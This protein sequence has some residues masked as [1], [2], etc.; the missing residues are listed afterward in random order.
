[1][2]MRIK[3]TAV[4]CFI[5]FTVAYSTNASA[6]DPGNTIQ[7]TDRFLSPSDV[8]IKGL[9]GQAINQSENGRL[10]SLPTWNDGALI[11]MFSVEARSKNNTTDWFGEHGGKW[12]YAAALA[13]KRTNS[14]TIKALLFKTADYLVS[15]QEA[16]GYLGSYSEALRITNPASKQHKKSWDVWSLS[17]MTLG[18]LQV[19]EY[20]PN[21]KY[22]E[23]AKKI[24]ELF[25]KTFGD[26][27]ANL[28]DYGTR[29]GIS[30]TIA[31]DPV[32]ELYKATSDERYLEF[33]KL[34]AREMEQKEGLRLVSAGLNNRDMETVADGKA[35]Q[36]IWNLLGVTKLYEVTGNAD[37][38]TAVKNAWQNIYDYH[39]SIAGGPWGGIGKHK[40]CFNTKGF[41]D[42]YGFVETCSTMSWIQLNKEL[43]HVTGEVKYA[44][45]IEKSAYNALLGAQFPNGTDWS[46]HSFSNGRRHVANFTDCCP[47]S[48]ML[49]LEE[50]SPLIYSRKES[51]IAINFYTDNEAAIELDNGNKVKLVEKT[52]YP[53][54]GKI[55]LT[56]SSSKKD[57]FPVFIRIPEW[58]EDA[59]VTIDGKP[60]NQTAIKKGTYYVMNR[61]WDKESVIEINF[62]VK[63]K[64]IQ[65]SEFAIVPQG[66][67]DIYRVGWTAL[68]R[69]PL[70]YA[71]SGLINGEDREKN[72]RLPSTNGTALFQPVVS[73]NWTGPVYQLKA[74]GVKPLF[75]APYYE[76]DHR[77]A[78]NWRLTWMQNSID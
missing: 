24:G 47:S 72:L 66:T 50:I 36:I 42:P 68:M 51:G 30:A 56:V 32:V 13:A 1:M 34:I 57:E 23:A 40:E 9:L 12:L 49:A 71:A 73:K 17:Y 43:L 77:T 48:G 2:M 74:N 16:D 54:D 52:N 39:L 11:K 44:Q 22:F 21:Q 3:L 4:T 58:A 6:H 55:R 35:Y 41:W 5:F 29:N 61:T 62:P 65:Q 46:Y 75:F 28:T 20:Y 19:N 14:E 31:L 45:E 63:L 33:A 60:V 10:L 67:A 25:L 38:L 7:P 18:L 59:T 8:R 76:A 64:L 70:V 78:G 15:T 27:K 26:G 53:F 69:G 37:Y